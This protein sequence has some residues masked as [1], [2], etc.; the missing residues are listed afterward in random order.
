MKKLIFI[1][2]TF[3][4]VSVA[5]ASVNI[6]VTGV[7]TYKTST[8]YSFL[9]SG[10][11]GY[12]TM[13]TSDYNYTTGILNDR[14][15]NGND[16]TSI[17]SANSTST[18]FTAG[19]IAG[20][21]GLNGLNQYI[22][23]VTSGPITTRGTLVAWVNQRQAKDNSGSN[24]FISEIMSEENNTGT[25][26]LK[27]QYG[28][29]TAGGAQTPLCV[30]RFNNTD[31]GVQGTP[32]PLNTWHHIAC[33]WT[34]TTLSLY[35]DGALI[36]TTTANNS[37]L[38]NLASYNIGRIRDS[39][40]RYFNGRLDDI[41]IYNRVLAPWE[42]TQLYYYGANRI[43]QNN[44]QSLNIGLSNCWP[45]DASSFTY[46]N[47]IFS[48]R[49][50]SITGTATNY[51]GATTT[52]FGPGISGS[53][54]TFNGTSQYL[55]MSAVSPVGA[56]DFS[57]S[58]WF[59]TSAS[60]SS[61]GRIVGNYNGGTPTNFWGTGFSNAN[62]PFFFCRDSS[63]NI[64]SVTSALTYNDGRWHNLIGTRSGNLFSLYVDG[65]LSATTSVVVGSCNNTQSLTIGADHYSATTESYFN[66]RI[67]NVRLYNRALTSWEVAQLYMAQQ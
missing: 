32:L 13:D 4:A 63:S 46:S 6:A 50:G 24:A 17:G 12:W 33:V 65:A 56:S 11:V 64:G 9:N 20:A 41:R 16:G 5:Q 51:T 59:N 49:V 10:L 55:Q 52:A 27:M 18:Y 21:V 19:K 40:S 54:L 47:G 29:A 37:P 31:A 2:L 53:A 15:G 58:Q 26:D 22:N 60:Y 3:L 36:S 35:V 62:K 1:L 61:T 39:N 7:S 42:I 38:I 23:T 44:C 66:G 30:Q 34:G 45:L 43:A 67:E 57:V 48:D 14:S 28:N 8:P 25:Y